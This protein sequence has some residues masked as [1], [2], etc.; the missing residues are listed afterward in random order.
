MSVV[1]GVT[2]GRSS[3]QLLLLQR[4]G[5]QWHG[6]PDLLEAI[7][8]D[9]TISVST[10]CDK[11]GILTTYGNDKSGILD[12]VCQWQEWHIGPGVAMTRL[13]YWTRCGNDKSDTVS[14]MSVSMTSFQ[15]S[16]MTIVTQRTWSVN[17]MSAMVDLVCQ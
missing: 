13:T 15:S 14:G 4:A 16:T 11:S 2:E 8:I 10:V 3:Q 1:G 17:E 5:R 7:V 12:Q 9:W 6:G